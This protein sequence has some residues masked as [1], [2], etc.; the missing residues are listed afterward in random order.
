MHSQPQAA[1]TQIPDLLNQTPAAVPV[2]SEY[3]DLNVN[4]IKQLPSVFKANNFDQYLPLIKFTNGPQTVYGIVFEYLK[5]MGFLTEEINYLNDVI[6]YAKAAAPRS[7]DKYMYNKVNMEAKYESKVLTLSLSLHKLA[8]NDSRDPAMLMLINVIMRICL[9]MVYSFEIGKILCRKSMELFNHTLQPHTVRRMLI[10]MIDDVLSVDMMCHIKQ[11]KD[12]T[13]RHNIYTIAAYMRK[14]GINN[15]KLVFSDIAQPSTNGDDEDIVVDMM[16]IVSVLQVILR[17]RKS[18]SYYVM[19]LPTLFTLMQSIPRVNYEPICRVLKN[20]SVLKGDLPTDQCHAYIYR[21]LPDIFGHIYKNYNEYYCNFVIND[22]CAGRGVNL[23]GINT[24]EIRSDHKEHFDKYIGVINKTV[25]EK[26]GSKT[27]TFKSIVNLFISK[28]KE[29]TTETKHYNKV[30]ITLAPNSVFVPVFKNQCDDCTTVELL[31]NYIKYVHDIM[32]TSDIHSKFYNDMVD[33]LEGKI[34]VDN[35][36]IKQIKKYDLD[37]QISSAG[38]IIELDAIMSLL[39]IIATLPY[40][41]ANF[42]QLYFNYVGTG[43]N[44]FTLQMLMN[45]ISKFISDQLIAHILNNTKH[46]KMIE[47]RDTIMEYTYDLFRTQDTYFVNYERYLDEMSSKIIDDSEIIIRNDNIMHGL[48]TMIQL[49]ISTDTI[50]K[51]I[52][53]DYIILK[54]SSALAACDIMDR[55]PTPQV[56]QSGKLICD[57]YNLDCSAIQNY[58]NMAIDFMATNI[59]QDTQSINIRNS[60]LDIKSIM[61]ISKSLNTQENTSAF[62]TMVDG[63]A[64]D[65]H[66]YV[67]QTMDNLNDVNNGDIPDDVLAASHNG[68]AQTQGGSRL[69]GGSHPR[70]NLMNPNAAITIRP[71]GSE[72]LRS[73][74]LSLEHI[75]VN[76]DE[77]TE[78]QK[79]VSTVIPPNMKTDMTE[80]H[81]KKK[82]TN[83][84]IDA[85]AFSKM[86]YRLGVPKPEKT[87]KSKVFKR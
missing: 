15:T 28:D 27:L 60:V 6:A 85:K 48:T 12:D 77:E 1:P 11:I 56:E 20:L 83:A 37:A 45:N 22:V 64:T 68:A 25:P 71:A 67:D 66:N 82:L 73:G 62:E 26:Q 36:D 2:A 32:P 69:Y 8:K 46:I 87:M 19:A 75:T 79:Y 5:Y 29:S 59:K 50:A 35:A 47:C 72:F 74:H 43:I 70:L 76:D 80:Y 7:P 10:T 51:K 61:H 49:A 54:I 58:R 31:N 9:C 34:T 33:I 4:I 24:T 17:D 42:R 41:M 65:I 44:T 13:I 63:L 57:F 23:P 16:I 84:E 21:Q 86:A 18:Y 30:N 14:I 52:S 3:G 39:Y 40:S 78:V 53:L 38:K 81:T 55:L